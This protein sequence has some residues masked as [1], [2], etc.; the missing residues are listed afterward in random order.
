[1]PYNMSKIGFEV[2]DKLC[3]K[4]NNDFAKKNI[5]AKYY[6]LGS[7]TEDVKRNYK[8]LSKTEK[9]DATF[10][11]LPSDSTNV[12]E[13]NEVE[14][15]FQFRSIKF[16]QTLKLKIYDNLDETNSIWD[17]TLKMDFKFKSLFKFNTAELKH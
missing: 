5:T 16:E 8:G 11:L 17:A 3:E 10:L 4:L 12:T 6:F 15:M 9:S 2:L 14:L 13:N 7:K 1:M